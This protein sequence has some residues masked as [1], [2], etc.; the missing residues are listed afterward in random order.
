M[1]DINFFANTKAAYVIFCCVVIKRYISIVQKA[2]PRN[3]SNYALLG[4][5]YYPKIN[6]DKIDVQIEASE[7]E[8]IVYEESIETFVKTHIGIF[9][10]YA[11]AIRE[12][13]CSY[14]TKY[15]LVPSGNLIFRIGAQSEGGSSRKLFSIMAEAVITLLS[16]DL[17]DI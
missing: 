6:D 14:L 2:L 17:T 8:N 9:P 13:V 1:Y 3:N 12:T 11:E 16:K 10:E 7:K 5:E 4:V 15:E